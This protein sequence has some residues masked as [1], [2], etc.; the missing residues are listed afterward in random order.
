VKKR[1]VGIEIFNIEAWPAR[2]RISNSY[3]SMR[4]KDMMKR[5]APMTD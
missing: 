5:T 3:I 1:V 4:K 2:E